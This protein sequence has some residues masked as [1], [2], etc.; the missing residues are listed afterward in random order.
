MNKNVIAYLEDNNY[1]MKEY[2]D[3]CFKENKNP[4][5]SEFCRRYLEGTVAE[6]VAFDSI[7]LKRKELTIF[8]RSKYK[9]WIE[10]K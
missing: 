4:N 1:I 3:E 8:L 9:L 5:Y 6:G 2:F 10:L 7:R